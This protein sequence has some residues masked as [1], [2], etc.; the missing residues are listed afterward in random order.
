MTTIARFAAMTLACLGLCLASQ[1]RADSMDFAFETPRGPD[2]PAAAATMRDL[3]ERL[4]PVYQDPDPDRYLAD[5]SALQMVVG[6]YD[7]AN[8]SRQS[9]RD[10]ARQMETQ[11]PAGRAVIF[12][13]YA[14]AKAVEADRHI[15]FDDSFTASFHRLMP[16]LDDLHAYKVAGWI[17]TSPAGFRNALQRAF[18]QQRSKPT[19]SE[20][21]ATQLIWSYLS[22]V[23]YREFGPLVASLESEDDRRR[24]TVDADVTIKTK[25]GTHISAMVIR[26]TSPAQALPTLLEFTADRS[27]SYA[28]E[29]AAHGFVGVVAYTRESPVGSR[30]IVPFD[31]DGD[32]ARAVINWI[33][34]QRW[35]DGRVGMYGDGYS[36]FTAWAAAKKLPKALKAIATY[37]PTAPGID[38]PMDAGVFRNSAF[39]WS[40]LAAAGEVTHDIGQSDADADKPS[41]WRSL[42]EKW[43]RSGRSYRDLG[44]VFGKPN[45]L[46]IRWL[47]HPSYD[48]YWRKFV[49]D[50][51]EYAAINIPVLTLTGFYATSEPG[52]LEYFQQ[53]T[54]HNP[55]A[56]HTLLIGPYGDSTIHNGPTPVLHGLAVDAA[57]VL[58]LRELRYQWFDHIFKEGA[59]PALLSDRVNYQIMG[60]NEWQH[61]PTLKAIPNES[62]RFHLVAGSTNDDHRLST[63]PTPNARYVSQIIP[64]ADRRDS[65]DEPSASLV[66]QTPDTRNGIMFVSDPLKTATDFAGFPSGLLDFTVNKMDLDLAVTLYERLANGEYVRLSSPGFEFRAS[67]AHDRIHR[68]LLRAGER[69]TLAFSSERLVSRRLQAGSQ[70]VIVLSIVKR[71][72]QEINYGTGDDVSAESIANAR[73]PLKVRWYDGSYLDI[74]IRK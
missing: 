67:Y 17:E 36:G 7:A 4:L 1:S 54:R 28:K 33:A 15:P 39:Q 50:A 61:V 11:R 9:L 10:R 2:D 18:D 69:Q 65:E 46:F 32:D 6:S 44:R 3:A 37:A 71:P 72:D 22:Y 29:C 16:E 19:I 24:Y 21:D 58:D 40:F 64:F 42:D 55:Q 59:L 35:S 13:I 43:Y 62:I 20:S 25:S 56:D 41:L 8:E 47:N 74:P 52:A 45:P 66:T 31:H 26:P 60:A 23:A 30:T 70:V 51:K 48:R 27:L 73:P 63:D 34:A 49:P 53:H 68:R 12:D 38:F 5:V 57:G 14:D